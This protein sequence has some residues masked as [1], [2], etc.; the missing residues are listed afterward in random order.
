MYYL[1]KILRDRQ[2]DCA[3][4][5]PSARQITRKLARVLINQNEW[6]TDTKYSSYTVFWLRLEL[7][8]PW[9]SSQISSFLC[10]LHNFFLDSGDNHLFDETQMI[11]VGFYDA[12]ILSFVIYV[13]L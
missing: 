11:F 5:R 13:V 3:F 6:K 7:I 2:C 12:P 1:T 4:M 8:Y 9:F 10:E